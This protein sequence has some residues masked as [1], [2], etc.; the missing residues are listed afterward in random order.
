MEWYNIIS[1]VLG[2]GGVVTAF[3]SLYTVKSKKDTIDIQNYHS[4]LE[5]ERAERESVRKEFKEYK[6]EVQHYKQFFKNKYDRLQ[7]KNDRLEDAIHLGYKCPLIKNS[8][9]CVIIRTVEEDE[10]EKNDC[11]ECKI[12]K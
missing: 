8:K 6:E 7:E 9:D 2:S 11:E 5:E 4:L 1:I 3:I 12:T 10:I